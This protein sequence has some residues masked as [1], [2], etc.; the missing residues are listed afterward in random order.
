MHFILIFCFHSI[1]TST[2][3]FYNCIYNTASN[4]A[5][6]LYLVV[7]PYIPTYICITFLNNYSYLL[8]INIL[9]IPAIFRYALISTIILIIL[10]FL[11]CTGT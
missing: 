6:I 4:D 5:L 9:Y 11:I 7:I 1:S 10:F 3:P 2:F 8:C